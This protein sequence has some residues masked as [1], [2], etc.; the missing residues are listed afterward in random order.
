MYRSL[1]MVDAPSGRMASARR[2]QAHGKIH[3][4]LAHARTNLADP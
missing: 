1:E 4:R 3:G 2:P